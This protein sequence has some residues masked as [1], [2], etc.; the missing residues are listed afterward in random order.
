MACRWLCS[1]RGRGYAR[2]RDT[3]VR[4]SDHTQ[5]E[6]LYG[7]LQEGYG[8]ES[9][10]WCRLCGVRRTQCQVLK[11][12][13]FRGMQWS[14]TGMVRPCVRACLSHGRSVAETRAGTT[15]DGPQRC[16]LGLEECAV[17][18]SGCLK[19]ACGTGGCHHQRRHRNPS[20]RRR[21]RRG[22]W[23]SRGHG[24]GIAT[25]YQAGGGGK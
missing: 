25:R 14:S 11:H 6:W 24:W 2:R 17:E 20:C 8:A 16:P 23:Q 19:N 22:L 9:C 7:D 12:L 13:V 10:N 4:K 1:R 18:W 21:C 3:C 15:V 5:L